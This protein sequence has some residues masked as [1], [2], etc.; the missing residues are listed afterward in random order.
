V[1]IKQEQGSSESKDREGVG[2]EREKIGRRENTEENTLPLPSHFF[3]GGFLSSVVV[4]RASVRFPF[5]AY[6]TK[7]NRDNLR[8]LIYGATHH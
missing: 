3:F 7:Y 8:K 5:Y 4:A 6:G 1:W 2:K